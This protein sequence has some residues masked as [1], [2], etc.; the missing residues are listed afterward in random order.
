MRKAT[1]IQINITG[2]VQTGKSVAL[3]S[4]KEMLE[5]DGYCVAIPDS[6]DTWI[7]LKHQ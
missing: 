2:P 3:A 5:N 7:S 6:A 1:V 4:I